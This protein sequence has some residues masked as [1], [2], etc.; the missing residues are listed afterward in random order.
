MH[1][2]TNQTLRKVYLHGKSIFSWQRICLVIYCFAIKLLVYFI[3]KQHWIYI[4][5]IF[6]AFSR[7]KD[8]STES[9]HLIPREIAQ[10]IVEKI[11]QKQPF[12]V[13][14]V[15]PMFPEGDPGGL[16]VQEQLYWQTRTMEMMY[17]RV[18]DAIKETG[19]GTHPTGELWWIYESKDRIGIK[20]L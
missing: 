9:Q 2:S 5:L 12:K 7:Y 19:N 1:G 20:M 8:Q 4:T 17:K 15:I 13:Y 3:S 11:S 16:L 10:R 14:I 6:W 18:G